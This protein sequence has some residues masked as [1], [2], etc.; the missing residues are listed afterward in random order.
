MKLLI[1]RHGIAVE[2]GTGEYQD[3]DRPL[4]PKGERKMY[5]VARGMLRLGL[6]FDCI[7]SSPYERAKRTAEIVAEVFKKEGLLV[8]TDE[9]AVGGNEAGLIKEIK[10]SYADRKE[11]L[12]VGHEPYL[13]F[14]VSLLVTG[15]RNLPV[16]LKKGSLCR[17]DVGALTS[18]QCATLEWLFTP[19]IISR[20]S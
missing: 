19:K 4:T 9:L 10:S 15:E 17:L 3:S 20:V 7:L 16:I 5:K 12:L 18:G 2:R 8:F 1:L 6:S 11:I 13:G 14:L